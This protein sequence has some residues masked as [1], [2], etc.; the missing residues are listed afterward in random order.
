MVKYHIF[1]LLTLILF[2]GFLQFSAAAEI[3]NDSHSKY[4]SCPKLTGRIVRK[5]EPNYDKARLVSNYYNSKNKFPHTIVY[6]KN[7]Q[8]VQNAVLWARCNKVPIRIRSG[9][10]NHEGYSTGTGVLL[11]D[12][13]EMKE[14]KVDKSAHIAAIQPGL[15]NLEL[16]SQ[17]FKEGFTHV[18]G[19]CSEVGLSGLVLSGGIGPLLRRIGLTCD[20]LISFEMIDA[21][22]QIIHATK[23]DE[24]KD[25]FWAICGGGGGNFGVITS[26]NIKIYPATD[27]TWF[28]IGWDW[29]QPVDQ[30]I[31][32]WQDFFSKPDKNWFSHLDLWAKPFPSE[33]LNKQPIKALGFFWGTPEQA[34]KQLA[35]LLNVGKPNSVVIELVDWDKAIKLIENSTAVFLTDKPEYKSSGAFAMNKLPPDALKI[36][37]SSLK[38]STSPLLNVL[39]FSMGGATAEVSPTDTA[40]YYRDAKFFINYSV[41]WLKDHEDQQ[42]KTELAVLRQRLLPYTVG[43][44]VG[45]PDPDLK[46]YLTAYYGKNVERLECVKRKYDPENL[47][48]YEQSIPPAPESCSQ[49]EIVDLLQKWS[50]DFNA[51]NIQGVCGL[52]APDL[53]ASYPGGKDRNYE[54]MCLYLSKAL[55]DPEKTF[56]YE[57][58]EIEQ[59]IIEGDLAVVRLVWLLQISYKHR[60]DI[61][62]I[63]EKGIDV[64]KRQKDGSWKIAISYAYPEQE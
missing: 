50:N 21:K 20:S 12:V 14:L 47:F 46:N 31:A 57:P 24:H 49:K 9:G 8:D 17:L 36:I 43:D 59:I 64:F 34:R 2:G 3:P 48:S 1:T 61:E 15:N 41:Q 30:V 13:S 45:N 26:M 60:S 51:K 22:G 33:K 16:Y 6:C 40:Y 63:K 38:E 44:Y 25:L 19:T 4:L 62:V 35:P 29:N 23:D 18:G 58:P 55:A 39:L 5:G 28:N 42:Q 52:F 7:T 54:E 11:I 32:A 53:I 27:V 10:H 56:T 37:D